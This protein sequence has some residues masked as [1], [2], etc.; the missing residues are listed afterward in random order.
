MSLHA[1]ILDGTDLPAELGLGGAS[2]EAWK[3]SF[4]RITSSGTAFP[5]KRLDNNNLAHELD[6]DPKWIDEKCGVQTRFVSSHDETTISLGAA[7][8]GA[9][10]QSCTESPDL[11]ICPPCTPSLTCCPSA[12]S[13]AA[14]VNLNGIG[15][16][17]LNAA[18]SGGLVGLIAGVSYL[19]SG[20]AK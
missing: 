18:C 13:I 14:R 19:V 2:G 3:Y 4:L 17:E 10:I 11:L 8:A 1:R 12:P 16:F 9:A 5:Q 15:A 7:A 20:F 6:V